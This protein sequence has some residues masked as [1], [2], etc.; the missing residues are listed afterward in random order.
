MWHSEYEYLEFACLDEMHSFAATREG[1]GLVLP[2]VWRLVW[3]E[4]ELCPAK[5][6]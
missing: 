2:R 6:L 4:S 1:L 5:L 3:I